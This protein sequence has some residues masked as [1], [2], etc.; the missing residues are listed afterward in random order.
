MDARGKPEHDIGA[1]HWLAPVILNDLSEA[2]IV[3]TNKAVTISY[4]MSYP[5]TPVGR[6]SML[7]V[8]FSSQ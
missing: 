2:L 1:D 4:T 7:V 8:F 3:A 6:P 5:K